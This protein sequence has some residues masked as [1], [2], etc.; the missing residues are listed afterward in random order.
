L[1]GGMPKT[2]MPYNNGQFIV[3]KDKF[4]GMRC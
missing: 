3:S 1:K 2:I 4:D